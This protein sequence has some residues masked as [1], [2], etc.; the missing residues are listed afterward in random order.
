MAREDEKFGDGEGD[1]E[2]LDEGPVSVRGSMIRSGERPVETLASPGV[3]GGVADIRGG[4]KS[5]LAGLVFRAN[6]NSAFARFGLKGGSEEVEQV[7]VDLEE[8]RRLL[9]GMDID[10]P[11]WQV[12]LSFAGRGIR[13][14]LLREEPDWKYFLDGEKGGRW[15]VETNVDQA[16][17]VLREKADCP[18]DRAIGK[19]FDEE[20]L[21]LLNKY[22][23][24]IVLPVPLDLSKVNPALN[25]WRV[26]LQFPDKML[27]GEEGE[28]LNLDLHEFMGLQTLGVAKCY[29]DEYRGVVE[30]TY[31][32]G[33]EQRN[34]TPEQITLMEKYRAR[35][36]RCFPLHSKVRYVLDG[37]G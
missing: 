14:Y 32:D 27:T 5:G 37:G 33:C 13:D 4:V 3:V 35:A 12:E 22:V 23:R 16:R 20:T 30:F 6:E 24:E 18:G 34:F 28:R 7:S 11:G 25:N 9:A 26:V 29:Y 1:V 10:Y 17:V 2:P 15:R 19:G 8:M 21:S 31:F 36:Y